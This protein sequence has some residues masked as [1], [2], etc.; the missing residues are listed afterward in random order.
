M[1]RRLS[2]IRLFLVLVMLFFIQLHLQAER[3]DIAKAEKVAANQMRIARQDFRK[4]LTL[5]HVASQRL[6]RGGQLRSSNDQDEPVYYI[7]DAEDNQGFVIVSADDVA[8]PV[9]GYSDD[10]CYDE[11][12]LNFNYWMD[13][14]SQEIASA[15]ENNIPQS[16]EI[17]IQWESFLTG[18]TSSLRSSAAAIAP[19][20]KTRWNQGAPFNNLCPVIGSERTVTGCVATAMA[21]VMKY[22]NYPV[23]GT[24]S[25]TYTPP[26]VGRDLFADFGNTTYDWGN[27]L[28][29]YSDNTVG[30]PAT[31][32]ATLMFHCGVAVNMNYDISSKGG[33]AA[34]SSDA[35]KALTAY[36]G[37]D[38]GI[39]HYYR[40]FLSYSQWTTV[41]KTELNNNRPVLYNGQGSGGGHAFV[42]DGYDANGLFHFNWGWGGSSD[43]YFELSALSPNSL[44]IGGGAGGYN[45]DQDIIV[46]VQPPTGTGTEIK[47]VKFGY[48]GLSIT[49]KILFSLTEEFTVE[50]NRFQ[51]IGNETLPGTGYAGIAI[52]DSDNALIKNYRKYSIS[53]T[54][55][56]SY[57]SD[58]SYTYTLSGLSAG[59]YKLYPVFY[60]PSAPTTPIRAEAKEG[61][62]EYLL[63][64]V[65]SENT[66]TIAYPENSLPNLSLNSLSTVGSLYKNKTGQFSATVTNSGA[67]EYNSKLAI[68]L[69]N[70][71]TNQIVC[72][73]PVVIA[74]GETKTVGFSGTV[75]LNAGT[76]TLS[77]L[78]DPDNNRSKFDPATNKTVLGTSG[79][80]TVKAEPTGNPN[81]TILGAQFPNPSQVN[82]D[83]PAFTAQIKNTGNYFEGY[84]GVLLFSSSST[85]SYLNKYFGL[86]TVML[87]QNETKVLEFNTPIDLPNGTYYASIAYINNNVWNLITNLSS[88]LLVDAPAPPAVSAN[89]DLSALTVSSGALSPAFNANTTDYTLSV[90]ND[91]ADINVTATAGN[92]NASANGD[93]NFALNVGDNTIT[94]Q[95]I[96]ENRT[97]TKTYS[98][99][100]NRA[101]IS[102]PGTGESKMIVTGNMVNIGLMNSTIP[103]ILQKSFLNNSGTLDVN[104]LEVGATSTLYNSG[105]LN[106]H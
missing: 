56:G 67:G 55:P 79:S 60:L 54:K 81:F 13:C 102:V 6:H 34:H 10:G 39:A 50:I 22:H 91:V 26:A 35:M 93:G 27:M 52:Y 105:T 62:P 103:M 18:N 98:I 3:V 24:G 101:D 21:Q 78:Y 16:D 99:V 63:I 49:P 51:N 28:D 4:K 89:A 42:C 2:I 97:T 82:K 75:T 23:R 92:A 87:D 11:N 59:T 90:P 69:N 57:Y 29:I 44:G 71:G 100:V 47:E 36:F 19:L 77:L 43:G 41:I 25:N 76:Y 68:Y 32:V 20:V 88:F 40:D 95:V 65:T 66:V 72:N 83:T 37:Y 104:G 74:A 12:N 85:N 73:D 80:A 9:L 96:A 94:I 84:M 1:K 15:I 33:S 17:K 45:S 5:S 61:T 38:L 58:L 70:G 86:Q 46:G 53:N 30:A 106:V 31:A 14:L 7:F 64:T 48:Q 8:K